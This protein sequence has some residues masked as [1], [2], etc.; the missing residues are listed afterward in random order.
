MYGIYQVL[1]EP[2]PARRWAMFAPFLNYMVDVKGVPG[3]EIMGKAMRGSEIREK[4]DPSGHSSYPARVVGLMGG[5][6]G[7]IYGFGPAGRIADWR[8]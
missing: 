8:R 2:P 3:V 7:R 4:K 6:K 5:P 1:L